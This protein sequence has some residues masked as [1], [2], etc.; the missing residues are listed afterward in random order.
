MLYNMPRR[1]MSYSLH[2]KKKG[3]KGKKTIKG[4]LLR[5]PNSKSEEGEVVVEC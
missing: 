3:W 1:A 2:K 5:M 4:L